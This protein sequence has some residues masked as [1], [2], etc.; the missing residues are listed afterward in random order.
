[1][2]FTSLNNLLEHIKEV[3]Q[4]TIFLSQEAQMKFSSFIEKN[5]IELDDEAVEALQ[6]QDIISQ[7]LN[8]TIEAISIVQENLQTFAHNFAEDEKIVESSSTVLRKKLDK[9][10]EE[11]KAKK[12]AF[13][14]HT[15][16]NNDE[17]EVEFF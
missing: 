2:I 9:V 11:A 12:D 6:Y 5:K 14:G 1:M 3:E 10:L 17:Y 7:Q 13:S 16:G 15:K 8:A 4:D